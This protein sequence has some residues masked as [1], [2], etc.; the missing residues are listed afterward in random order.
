MSATSLLFQM[1]I[2]RYCDC[3]QSIILNMESHTKPL[4]ATHLSPVVS[5]P[6]TLDFEQHFSVI[7]SNFYSHFNLGSN[8][9]CG[10]MVSSLSFL[11][12]RAL[13]LMK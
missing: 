12:G 9:G 1:T 10:H 6:H 8:F 13:S 2:I 4:E 11:E 3:F 7:W 5:N